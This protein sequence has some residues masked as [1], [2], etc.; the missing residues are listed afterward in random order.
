[1]ELTNS[2]IASLRGIIARFSPG[3]GTTCSH[4]RKHELR[5]KAAKVLGWKVERTAPRGCGGCWRVTDELGHERPLPGIGEI[6]ELAGLADVLGGSLSHPGPEKHIEQITRDQ[7]VWLERGLLAAAVGEKM[8]ERRRLLGL[9]QEAC[10]TAS[11][12]AR[13]QWADLEAGRAGMSLPTLARI[14]AALGL[15]PREL[16]P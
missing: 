11:G 6:I 16:L 2:Q 4:G 1:M 7:N 13:S 10:A 12:L 8:A 5:V 15:R 3:P 14:A 9:T